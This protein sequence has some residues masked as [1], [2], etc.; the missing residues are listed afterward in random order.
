LVQRASPPPPEASEH[1]RGKTRRPDGW[2][3]ENTRDGTRRVAKF[4]TMLLIVL[5]IALVLFVAATVVLGMALV[6]V[7]RRHHPRFELPNAVDVATDLPSLAGITYGQLS[8]GNEVELVENETYLEAS[9]EIVESGRHTVHFE[10]FLW[11][12]GEMSARLTAALIERARAGVEV[13]VLVDALGGRSMKRDELRALAAAGVQIHLFR[14]LGLRN[15]AWLNKRTHRKILVADGQRAI[16]GGHCV[17]DRWWAEGA[18]D[19]FRDL[20]VRVEGPVVGQIQSAFCENWIEATGRVP[21]GSAVFPKLS[22]V[23]NARVHVAYVHPSGGVP[24]TKLLHYLAL[25]VATK[26]LWIQTPYFLPDDFARRALI[27]AVARGVDVRV[28]TPTLEASDN[29]LVQHASHYRLAPLLERGVRVYHYAPT[30]LHQK[31]WTVDGSYALVGSTNFDERSF[32]LDDQVTLGVADESFVQS[33][34][35][36]FLADVANATP[37]SPARWRQRSGGEKLGDALA[38]LLREHL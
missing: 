8:E 21:Y 10:T 4:G 19:P 14:P 12:T 31:V 9:I 2:L 16:V 30:L 5:A 35:V 17:D 26:R 6:S 28:L 33:I 32:D 23:G 15:L 29:R 13:R 7:H 36:R 25:R 24:S 27:D 1:V 38:Y 18:P 20:S 11:R 3:L 37:V 34:D 22:P